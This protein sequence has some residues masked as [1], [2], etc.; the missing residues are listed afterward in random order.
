VTGHSNNDRRCSGVANSA[1]TVYTAACAQQNNNST[2]VANVHG[3]HI[4]VS[5][6][7]SKSQEFT[8]K[9]LLAASN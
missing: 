2:F 1:T 5:I 4:I 3:V 6:I 8:M 7:V 9:T